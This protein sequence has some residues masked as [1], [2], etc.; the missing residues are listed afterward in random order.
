MCT[1]DDFRH[2]KRIVEQ[3]AAE[4]ELKKMIPDQIDINVREAEIED[5]QKENARLR[6]VLRE[7]LYHTEPSF[8]YVSDFIKKSLKEIDHE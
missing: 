6:A 8:K 7:V 2:Y 5:L 4:Q 1:L 3:E